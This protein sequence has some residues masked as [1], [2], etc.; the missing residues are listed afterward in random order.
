MSSSGNCYD[1]FRD[2]VLGRIGATRMP[3]PKGLVN[4]LVLSAAKRFFSHW[5]LALPLLFHPVWTVL[6][7]YVLR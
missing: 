3:R 5:L 7:F 4:S 2:V 1:D 6:L